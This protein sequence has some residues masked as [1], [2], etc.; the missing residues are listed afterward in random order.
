MEATNVKKFFLPMKIPT[1]TFQAKKLA[2]RNGK[3][4]LYTP[5]ELK[6][7]ESLYI[8]LLEKYKPKTPI[9]GAVVLDLQWV[10]K[11]EKRA[12]RPKITKP[13][14]DNLGKAFK[15]CMTTVGYWHD[16]CQIVET[17]EVKGYGRREGI[18]VGIREVREDK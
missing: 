15:D 5:P 4:V 14:L 10:F 16:D 18:Y 1:K 8:A 17:H 13:D 2:V 11:D 12:G 6:E 3:A 7:I 9:E